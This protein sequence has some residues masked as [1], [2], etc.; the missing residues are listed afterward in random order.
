[1]VLSKLRTGNGANVPKT[2][3]RVECSR[4]AFYTFYDCGVLSNGNQCGMKSKVSFEL[5]N[6]RFK[7]AVEN[8]LNFLRQMFG[9]PATIR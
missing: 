5:K 8:K 2:S 9:K 1:V 7:A 4:S 3:E 6:R